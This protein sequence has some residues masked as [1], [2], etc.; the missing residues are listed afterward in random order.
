MQ[1][2]GRSGASGCCLP[3]GPSL[4]SPELCIRPGLR[5]R[6]PG[7]GRVGPPLRLFLPPALPASLRGRMQ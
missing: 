6:G 1:A 7:A 5:A 2:G 3:R 4:C